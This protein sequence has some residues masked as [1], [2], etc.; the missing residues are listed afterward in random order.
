MTGPSRWTQATTWFAFLLVAAALSACVTVVEQQRPHVQPQPQVH[1]VPSVEGLALDRAR[2]KLE[3]AGYRLGHVAKERDRYAPPRSVLW[4]DPEPYTR[5]P[6]GSH[7][8]VVIAARARPA[9][10]PAAGPDVGSGA[11]RPQAQEGPA[12]AQTRRPSPWRRHRTLYRP[13]ARGHRNPTAS[14]RDAAGRVWQRRQHRN[15][16]DRG[17][18]AGRRSQCAETARPAHR[19]G[20]RQAQAGAASPGPSHGKGRRQ[21]PQGNRDRPA[22]RTANPGPA[23]QRGR[24]GDRRAAAEPAGPRG[25]CAEIA[26]PA[27][28]ESARQAQAGAAS[29]GPSHGKGRRQRPQGNRDRPAAR[30]A[31]PGPGPA[32]R[33]TW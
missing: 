1:L 5:A 19:E 25:Q 31:N 15:R 10:R 26:R 20:P 11:S 2:A 28:R 14:P 17:Q 3:H 32:A 13:R 24:P 12:R 7:V 18:P 16:P 21:R 29:P 8:D 33:S 4:Q 6:R 30:A 27:P 9:P 22:A 23:R